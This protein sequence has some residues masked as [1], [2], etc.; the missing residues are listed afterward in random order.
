MKFEH[1]L[2]HAASAFY[3]SP[4]KNAL[5]ITM[6][7]VGEWASTSVAIGNNSEIRM[8]KD[9]YFPNSLEFT[10]FCFYIFRF[11][12]NSGEYKVMGLAPYGMPKY[13]KEIKEHLINIYP[14]GSFKL[15]MKYFDYCINLKMTNNLF[16]N[17]FN[18]EPRKSEVF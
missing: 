17:I 16:N 14:D 2:S 12:V 1:H 3:P 11:K 13:V 6:D 4:F 7:G 15:N 9:V 8:I 10:L 5:I 18:L